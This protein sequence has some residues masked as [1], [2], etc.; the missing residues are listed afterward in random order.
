MALSGSRRRRKLGAGATT[1]VEDVAGRGDLL[2]GQF[3]E[4]LIYLVP[5][6][7]RALGLICLWLPQCS[8]MELPRYQDSATSRC[9]C[10]PPISSRSTNIK[11]EPIH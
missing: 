9:L 8:K 4:R 2:D 1:N 3:L 10:T 11:G 5:L 7:V 6:K